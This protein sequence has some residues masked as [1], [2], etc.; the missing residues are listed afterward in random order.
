MLSKI[1]LLHYLKKI[2][3]NPKSIYSYL[4]KKIYYRRIADKNSN[5]YRNIKYLSPKDTI[6]YIID[7]NTSLVR[8]GDGTFSYISGISIYFNGWHFRYNKNFCRRLLSTL[9]RDEKKVL[10][11]F[12]LPQ[13]TK[14]KK[15]YKNDGIENEWNIWVLSKVLA[16]KYL[17]TSSIYGDSHCF[18]P[19]YSDIDYNKLKEYL[20]SKNIIIVSS[21]IELVKNLKLGKSLDT[22]RAPSNDAWEEYDSIFSSITEII[23]NNNYK[24][25]EV[26]VMASLCEAAK[27]LVY[28]LSDLGYTA[29]D[30]GQF[31]I[32]AE[33]EISKFNTLK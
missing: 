7:N 8:Y 26:L 14:T 17:K 25:E 4:I 19:K 2:E 24:K 27:V 21:S 15:E 5:Y 31:F 20:S 18:H 1:E 12:P 10:A 29:W 22:V 3:D 33:R 28:D 6:N 11:C 9:N 32:L 30:T 23:K 16:K 13:I